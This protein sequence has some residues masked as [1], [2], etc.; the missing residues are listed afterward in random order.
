AD[1]IDMLAGS[2]ATAGV[3]PY[4]SWKKLPDDE[5]IAPFYD[6]ERINIVVVGGETSPL[7]KASDYN[8]GISVSIDKWR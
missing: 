8:H 5:L 1:H 6:P 4:A 2:R 3:E 7:W